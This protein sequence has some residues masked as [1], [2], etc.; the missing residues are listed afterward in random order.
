M[1]TK[2]IATTLTATLLLSAAPVF[3]ALSTVKEVEVTADLTVIT[4]VKAA[5]YWTTVADDLENAIVANLVDRIAEDG[6]KISV[7]IDELSLASSFESAANIADS[8]L[9]G[10]VSVTHANDNTAFDAYAL[11][12]GIAD[13]GPFFPEGTDIAMITGDSKEHYDAM[14]AAFAAR[15]VADLK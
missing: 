4:N 5:A 11:A 12:V 2:L 8:K 10:A 6:A 13:A 7:D 15:V 14:I 9:V 1:F 3:A